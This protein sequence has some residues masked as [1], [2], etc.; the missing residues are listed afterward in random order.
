MTHPDLR[1]ALGRERQNTLLADAEAAR[2]ARQARLHRRQAATPARRRSPLQCRAGTGTQVVLQD[3][4]AVVIRQVHC[5]DAPLLADVFARLS[6]ASRRMRFLRRKDELSPAELR[7]FTKVDHHDHEALG[8]LDDR[9]GR[10]VGV[11][12]YVRHADD[13]QTAEIAVTVVDAWQGRGLGTELLIQL[14]DCARAE[15]I[16][17]FTAL[18]ADDNGAAAGLLRSMRA[19]LRRRN[20]GTAEYE[21]SLSPS[22]DDPQ[23]VIEGLED[24]PRRWAPARLGVTPAQAEV[25]QSS[26]AD[27]LSMTWQ[28][29]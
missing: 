8:A 9:T 25:L 1:A 17:R 16:Q 19:H 15:C 10:R 5:D 6:A 20:P 26:S 29:S 11:A 21:I 28:A 3:G 22:G 12:R 13:S 2:T 4:S 14:A 23:E 24:E 18:V 7:Y 27:S